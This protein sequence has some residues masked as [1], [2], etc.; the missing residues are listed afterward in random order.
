MLRTL[1]KVIRNPALFLT[2]VDLAYMI[3]ELGGIIPESSRSAVARAKMAWKCQSTLL[4]AA[5][6]PCGAASFECRCGFGW[7]VMN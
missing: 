6:C 2:I 3:E 1:E 7:Q 5:R 4:Y